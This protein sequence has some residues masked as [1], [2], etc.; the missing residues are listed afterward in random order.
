MRKLFFLL[1]IAILA[2][3]GCQQQGTSTIQSGFKIGEVIG[4]NFKAEMYMVPGPDVL[5]KEDPISLSFLLT[6]SGKSPISGKVKVEDVTDTS[7]LGGI[8]G[9]A[10]GDFIVNG[11]TNGISSE[12]KLTIPE[13]RNIVYNSEVNVTKFI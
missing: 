8:Q 13:A 12:Y 7:Q 11:V 9:Q 10:Q 3:G 6:N 1:I 2:I 4:T 5:R